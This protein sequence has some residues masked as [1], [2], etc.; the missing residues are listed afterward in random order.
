MASSSFRQISSAGQD[1]RLLW[2]FGVVLIGLLSLRFG[3][4]FAGIIPGIDDMMRLQQVRDLLDGQAWFDVDQ[5]RLLTPEGG[6][7][8]WSRLPDLFI[9]GIILVLRPFLG[10]TLAEMLTIG[11][12][13]LILLSSVLISL[14]L[15]MRRMGIGL[16]GQLIGLFSFATSAAIFNFWPGRIDHHGFVLALVLAGLAALLSKSMSGR[17]GVILAFCLSAALSIAIEALPYV[18]GLI[19]IIGLFWI[20][21]GHREGVRL[22]MFGGSILTF[23]TLFLVFDAPGLGPARAVC[24][25]YGLSHW[26]ALAFGGALLALLGALG[27]GLDT[28]PKRLVAGLLAG[29]L[30]LALFVSV[31]PACLGDPYAAVPD[32]VRQSWLSAVA[33][34]RSL[35]Y[36]LEAEPDR[37]I[38]VFGFLGVSVGA[39]VWMI[40]RAPGQERLGRIGFALLLGLAIMAT[41]W[42]IRGQSFSLAFAA[43][44][45]GGAA[46]AAFDVWKSRRGSAALLIFAA[47][48]LLLS[49]MS[50]RILGD[51]FAVP[52]EAEGALEV[53]RYACVE[54]EN[55]AIFARTPKMKVHTPIDLGIP[56]LV[57]SEHEVFVGPYH[58]NV[59][60]I[61]RA[62]MVLIGSPEEARQRL[63]EMGATHLAYC[64]GLNETDR[65]GLLW[66]NG[67]AAALNQ[68]KRPDWLV[69]VDELTD[70]RGI[71]RLYRV[72][73]E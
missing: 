61:E 45:A 41:V 39:T 59:K 27:G 7:M 70:T 12:W 9:A 2:G 49:P 46:G 6:E 23:S 57:R 8:H 68:D 65:Y 18:A 60:G 24:D 13:P 64:V 50:W 28:W 58:R 69:P 26:A 21:R 22:A 29:G 31:N 30:T 73:F 11:L 19:A 17:S 34:A 42:Q 62:N 3:D 14:C 33:E 71:V 25:A 1:T 5:M 43:I 16:A 53:S 37:V 52:T 67:L 54:P 55:F 32:S 56:V 36:L 47:L 15:I 66:P 20:V 35:S 10:Q 63:L 40:F 72:E 51:Q 48:A 4:L 44:A 38:A